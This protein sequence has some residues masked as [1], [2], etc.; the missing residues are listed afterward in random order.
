MKT[1]HYDIASITERLAKIQLEQAALHR[2]EQ[3]LIREVVVATNES[4]IK[5]TV[6]R[7]DHGWHK[8]RTTGSSSYD[9]IKEIVKDHASRGKAAIN[10]GEPKTYQSEVRQE[11]GIEKPPAKT[12]RYG[13]E[14]KVGNH[15]EFLTDGLYRS[16]RWKI[17][18]LTDTRVL[19]KR[20]GSQK[21]H[22]AYN[23]VR[24]L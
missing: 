14:L 18:K 15:V 8:A 6:V 3:D 23:N 1:R 22:R 16:K 13:K 4:D 21:T 10:L 9:T 7:G 19:C 11:V 12:D 5:H 24:K 2:E 20:K 17:Y